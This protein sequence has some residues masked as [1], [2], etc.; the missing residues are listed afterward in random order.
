[1]TSSMSGRFDPANSLGQNRLAILAPIRQRDHGCSRHDILIALVVGPGFQAHDMIAIRI[2]VLPDDFAAD[3]YCIR[4]I[5]V[6][7]I[8]P[9]KCFEKARVARPIG[10]RVDAPA[11]PLDTNVICDLRTLQGRGIIV[12]MQC[13]AMRPAVSAR[14]LRR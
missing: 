2:D 4:Q 6:R 14:S 5:D 11:G 10:Q 12:V 13:D 1:M 8:L 3:P 9:E 7:A